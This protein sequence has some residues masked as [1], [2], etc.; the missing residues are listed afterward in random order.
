MPQAPAGSPG[1]RNKGG[2]CPVPLPPLYLPPLLLPGAG[3]HFWEHFPPADGGPGGG[4]GPRGGPAQAAPQ[5]QRT[6]LLY[7]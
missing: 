3:G 7:Y 4:P 5:G 2:G 1:G 6:L